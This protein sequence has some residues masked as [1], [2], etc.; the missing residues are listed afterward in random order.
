M[1]KRFMNRLYRNKENITVT[2]MLE[3]IKTTENVVLLDVRSTSEY[4][5]GHISGSINIPVYDLVKV[6]GSRL[7]NKESIIIAYCSAG[8][9]SK[10]AVQILRKLGYKNLYN[11]EGGIKNL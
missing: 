7:K 1:L 2:E 10:R 4:K 6:A 9:R 3:M 5:E 11:I 8:T